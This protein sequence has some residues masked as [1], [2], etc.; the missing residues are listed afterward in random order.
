MLIAISQLLIDAFII[1]IC[2]ITTK[3]S[4]N[5]VFIAYSTFISPNNLNYFN[6]NSLKLFDKCINCKIDLLTGKALIIFRC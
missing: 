4:A 6:R 3:W 2:S 5:A 1:H